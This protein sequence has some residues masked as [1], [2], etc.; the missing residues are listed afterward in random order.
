MSSARYSLSHTLSYSPP[1]SLSYSSPLLLHPSPTLLHTVLPASY[2]AVYV[3]ALLITIHYYRGKVNSLKASLKGECHFPIIQCKQLV[4][5]HSGR[6]VQASSMTEWLWSL[7]SKALEIKGWV[8]N[9]CVC[10]LFP[11]KIR[12]ISNIRKIVSFLLNNTQLGSSWRWDTSQV[13]YSIAIE[14]L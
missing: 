8:H 12:P 7:L 4:I 14:I 2:S 3:S 6:V 11:L 10:L 1:L 5:N 13:S 9:Q